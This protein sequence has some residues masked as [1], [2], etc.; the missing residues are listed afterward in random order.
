MNIPFGHP[1]YKL[2]KSR[3]TTIRGKSWMKKLKI[4]DEVTIST[5]NGKFLAHV[6]FLQ[7]S[8]IVDL[9]L[10]MLKMDAEYPGLVINTKTDFVNLINSLRSYYMPV[11]TLESQVTV[12]TLLRVPE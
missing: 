9:S 7:V 10:E 4:G 12:I 8:R 6:E 11:A 1:Y 2:E 3:F 5:L